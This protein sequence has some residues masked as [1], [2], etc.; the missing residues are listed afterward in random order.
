[1]I[2]K[3]FMYKKPLLPILHPFYIFA[4]PFLKIIILRINNNSETVRLN[5]DLDTST[6]KKNWFLYGKE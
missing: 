1:M 2:L 5:V 4:K 3:M 6:L